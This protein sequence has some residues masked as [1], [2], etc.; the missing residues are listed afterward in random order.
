MKNVLKFFLLFSAVIFYG[1]APEI[2][3]VEEAELRDVYVKKAKSR[4]E[5]GD[6]QEATEL[7][8]Q[9]ITRKPLNATAHLQ[10]AMLYDT[11]A[12]NFLKAIYHY[13]RYL[14]LR[15][16]AEKKTMVKELIKKAELNYLAGFSEQYREL[17]KQIATLREENVKLK[18]ELAS[19]PTAKKSTPPQL[20]PQQQ[21]PPTQ[22]QPTPPET[23][24]ASDKSELATTQHGGLSDQPSADIKKVEKQKIVRKAVPEKNSTQPISTPQGTTYTVQAGDTLSKIAACFYQNPRLWKKIYEANKSVLGNNEKLRKGQVLI[25]PK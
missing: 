21:P 4:I 16:D 19:L 23:S 13:Q 22:Q 11:S 1:C 3:D 24:E 20:S 18:T 7:L 10:L 14:E 9:A 6:K 15:P 12:T 25:I 5:S 8:E 2:K 17:E